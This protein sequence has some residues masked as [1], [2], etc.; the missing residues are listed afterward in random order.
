MYQQGRVYT[1]KGLKKGTTTLTVELKAE[2]KETFILECEI[3]VN[4]EDTSFSL[5]QTSLTID[6][7]ETATV[8]VFSTGDT[9]G[10][11]RIY[12]VSDLSVANVYQQGRIYTIKGLKK[13]TTTL[14]VELIAEGKETFILECEITVV[15]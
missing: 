10:Y 4:G 12:D 9:T 11:G 8:E 6:V 3:T 14:T 5:S 13:G 2:G 7:G 1:I 15:E